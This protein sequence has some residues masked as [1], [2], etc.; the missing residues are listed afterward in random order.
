LSAE[1]YAQAAEVEASYLRACRLQTLSPLELQRLLTGDPVEAASW[2]ASAAKHG[3]PWAQLRLGQMLLDGTGAPPDPCMALCWFT[4]AADAGLGEAMNMVG[5]CYEN[6]WGAEIDLSATAAWYRRSAEAGHDWGEYNYAHMLFD[7]RGVQHDLAEAAVWYARAARQGHSRAMN[8]LARCYEEG[9][10]VAR[11]PDQAAV[12]YRRSAEAGYFRAQYNL[13]TLL[14]G[15]GALEEALVW[16]EAA[17]SAA[18]RPSLDTM[19]KA[20]IAHPKARLQDLGRR[21]A[22]APPFEAPRALEALA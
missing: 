21:M 8:L 7:G 18:P 14:V 6:G 11:A 20:L 10:G 2:I 5:R 13:A 16:F 1:R 4:R 22:P 17:L 3:V 12:W 19:A 9:W 15:A